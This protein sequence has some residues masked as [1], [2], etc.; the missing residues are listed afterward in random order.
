[1]E[2]ETTDGVARDVLALVKVQEVEV[3]ET[4]TGGKTGVV[5]I[6]E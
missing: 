6:D 2:I 4:L 1:M 5:A 3:E